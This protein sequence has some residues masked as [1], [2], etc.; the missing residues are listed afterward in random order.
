MMKNVKTKKV[1]KNALIAVGALVLASA[2]LATFL[3]NFNLGLILAYLL[4]TAVLSV[5]LG[6]EKTERIHIFFKALFL[7]ALVG[8]MV[9]VISLFICGKS[10]TVDYKEDAIIVLGAGIRGEKVGKGL[11]GR[12][13]AAFEYHKSNPDAV[14]IVSGGQGP[15][16]SITEAL[17]MERYLIEKGVPKD[18]IIKEEASTSTNENFRFSKKLLEERFGSEYK[19]AFVTTDYHIY[20][21]ENIAELE[22][23]ESVTHCHSDIQWYVAIPSGLR[24][25]CAVL[26]MWV[27]D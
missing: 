14:I 22:G 15:Q 26:K 17:A 7:I 5:G 12:L 11:Q 19:T 20:R 16:E 18:K 4:G 21:A 27:F 3:S 25:M 23:F 2:I 6:Y 10:D 13:D 8:I 1:I 24:E 9:F